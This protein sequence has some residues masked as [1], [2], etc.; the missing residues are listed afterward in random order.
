M[1]RRLAILLL[2]CAAASAHWDEGA[3]LPAWAQ[4]GRLHWALQYSRCDRAL[5]DLYLAHGQNLVQGATFDSPATAAYA[6]ERGLRLMPYVCS[7]TFTTHEREKSPELAEAP[8]QT[9]EGGEFL[10]Y[11]NPVRRYG[12]LFN[13]VWPEYV[14]ER[15]RRQW[16]GPAVSGIFYDNAFW[17]GADYRPEAVATWQ[18][19]ARAQGLDPGEGLPT[20]AGDPRLAAY[21]AFTSATLS[22]YYRDLREFC[23]AHNPPLLSAPNLASQ[24]AFGL[25]AAEQGALDLVFYE[26]FSHPPFR[27][28]AFLYKIG[29]AA[30]HGRSTGLLAYLPAAIGEQRGVKTWN[31][32]MHH[33]FYPSSPLPEEFALAAAEG[34]ANGGTYIPC[35][36]LFPALPI[37]D[38]TDPFNQRV[39]REL[40][41]SY[42][43]LT[44]NEALYAGARP[45]SRVG[46]LYSP[47]T[48]VQD[49]A[50]QQ[51]WALGERL[52]AAGIPYEVVVPSDLAE[53]QLPELTTLVVPNVLYLEEPAAAGLRRFVERGGRLLLTGSFATFDSVGRA[54]RPPSAQRL[55]DALGLI[56][57]PIETWQLTGY[58]PETAG[59]VKLTGARGQASLQFDGRPGQYRAYL[60]LRDEADGAGSYRLLAGGR[61]ICTGRLDR[62]DE[63][64]HWLTTPPFSL[65]PGDTVTLQVEADGGEQGRLNGVVLTAAGSAGALK[66]GQGELLYSPLALTSDSIPELIEK[67]QPAAR[68]TTPGKVALN[69]LRTAAGEDS[70]HLVNYDFRYEVKPTGRFGSD[71]GTAE[72]RTYL[73]STQTVVRKRL[74]VAAPHEVN[75][76]VLQLRASATPAC[77]APLVVTVNG[78]EV[79]RL[80]PATAQSYIWHEL[81]LAREALAEEMIVDLRAEGEVDGQQRWWQVGIDTSQR[82]NSW[83][84]LDGGATF[85]QDDLSPDRQPQAGEYLIRLFDAAPGTPDIPGNLAAN[86]SFERVNVLNGNTTLTVVPAREV[87]LAVAGAPRPAVAISPDGPPVSITGRAA[88]NETLYRVP[89]VS[90]YSVLVLGDA[91]RTAALAQRQVELSPWTAPP[92]TAPLREVTERWEGYGSGFGTATIAHHGQRSVSCASDTATAVQGAVQSIDL[93]QQTAT[94]LTVTAWSRAENVGGQPAPHYSLDVDA[95]YQDGAPLSGLN[96]PF[97]TGSHDWQQVELRIQPAKPLRSLRLYVLFRR[98]PGKVWFDDVRLSATP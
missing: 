84:S 51:G 57:Q 43:F 4:P 88:G 79:G 42:A 66:V 30:S 11:S 90:I 65:Q 85:R 9:A 22:G 97:A 10:A 86:G 67:L 38:L 34:A 33:F 55:L 60:G 59:Q 82:G 69:H 29:L 21:R 80:A 92:V 7:R 37:T 63:R 75:Q 61:S 62:D 73:G 45:G 70:Y 46:L 20:A 32:G 94:P 19:W 8:V 48:E 14:R 68:L 77:Q 3:S 36:S 41:R 78:R 26:T 95:V 5:V 72:A 98:H 12:S 25:L 76:P 74:V 17:S 40:Q 6:A 2:A 81:P 13:G 71:D 58:L 15:T 28:N 31:E 1:S 49:R 83:F 89:E 18:R 91:A 87:E 54:V 23:A 16:T 47:L 24:N 93:Q 52:A 35:Y 96:A 53:D 64:V 56:D 27:N 39:H 44:G 50:A